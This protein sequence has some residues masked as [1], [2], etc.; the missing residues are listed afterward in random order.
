MK[1][2]G[3]M[4]VEACLVLP[5]F[6][7]AGLAIIFMCRCR[8]AESVIYE[9]AAETAEYMAEYAYLTDSVQELSAIDPAVAYVQMHRYID[10]K[11]LVDRYVKGGE[12]GILLLSS[13][14][15]DEDGSI[16]LHATYYLTLN[17]PL[18]C[19]FSK[20]KTIDIEQAAYLGDHFGED[21]SGISDDE[22]YVYVTDNHEV[23]HTT[24]MCTYLHYDPESVGIDAAKASGRHECEFC[25]SVCTGSVWVTEYGDAYHSSPACASFVRSIKRVRLSE[26]G[27]PACS[28]CGGR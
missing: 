18:I 24:A 2:K 5:M 20:R 25:G 13:E 16:K 21:E 11:T 22:I 19:N 9:A 17:V 23:Y 1:N 3:S 15:P 10:D 4:T 27:V 12:N 6:L 7:L 28:K 14:F 26:A 8:A